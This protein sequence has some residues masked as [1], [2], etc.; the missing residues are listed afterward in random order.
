MHYDGRSVLD[1]L[2]VR[3]P[4]VPNP[5]GPST[6]FCQKPVLPP[7]GFTTGSSLPNSPNMSDDSLPLHL[8]GQVALQANYHSTFVLLYDENAHQ[9]TLV[10]GFWL[11]FG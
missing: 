10:N 1:S 4:L 7:A 6:L 8:R 3:A 11:R 5:V 9:S 2:G